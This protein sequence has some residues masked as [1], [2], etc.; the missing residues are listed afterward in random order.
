[1]RLCAIDEAVLVADK[2]GNSWKDVP[3]IRSRARFRR[4]LARARWRCPAWGQ[5]VTVQLTGVAA[6]F[7]LGNV[8]STADERRGNDREI[9]HHS[10]V[11]RGARS[12]SA[13]VGDATCI[14]IER[15][16]EAGRPGEARICDRVLEQLRRAGSE[17]ARMQA[18]D[19]RGEDFRVRIGAEDVTVQITNVPHDPAFW[20]SVAKGTH[21]ATVTIDAAVGWIHEAIQAK[22]HAAARSMLL[23]L[24]VTHLGVLASDRVVAAYL[25]AHGDPA[26]SFGFG[27]V[28]LVGPTADAFVRLGTS[29]W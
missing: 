28:W 12:R 13:V 8:S 2:A 9:R 15:P 23:A 6:E 14:E 25:K 5:D 1:M 21:T 10:G 19:D 22:K 11:R 24:D 27:A 29:R 20:S 4:V 18:R 3:G 7:R 16:V 17:V 26:P